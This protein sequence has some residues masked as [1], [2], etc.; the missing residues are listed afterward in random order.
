MISGDRLT[1][2]DPVKLEIFKKI[3]PSYGEAAVPVDLFDNGIPS[4]FAL[5]IKKSFGQ[6]TVAGFFNPSL[7]ETAENNFSLKRLWLDPHKTYIAFD[8]WNQ[9]FFGEVTDELKVK[10]FPG[11][12]TLLVLHE[13]TGKPQLLS[14]DRHVLQGAIEIESIDWDESSKTLSGISTGPL[15]SSH[16]VSVY[17]PGEHPWIWGGYVLFR[18]FD[19][20]SLKLVHNNIIQVHVRFEKNNRIKWEINVDEFFK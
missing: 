5:K 13:K 17:V 18:D 9:E 6:W 10:T 3:T 12:V 7:T 4:V 1:Q 2:L 8:F 16:N 11:S 14:T 19:S 20:Y 15:N